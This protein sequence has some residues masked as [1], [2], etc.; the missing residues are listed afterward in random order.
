MA[1]FRHFIF[2]FAIKIR[3]KNLLQTNKQS[4]GSKTKSASTPRVS[5]KPAI[6]AIQG[7]PLKDVQ[8]HPADSASHPAQKP[9]V[10]AININL[11][12]HISSDASP[13]QIDKIFE[14]MSKHIYKDR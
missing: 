8:N 9:N 6:P 5:Q 2:S 3:L 12:I 7:D 13:E 1:K 11:Q 4:N 10:P 14:S